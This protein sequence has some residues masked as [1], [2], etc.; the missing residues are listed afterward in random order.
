MWFDE[1]YKFSDGTLKKVR[2]ELHHRIHDFRLEYNKMM[3]RRKWTAIDRKRDIPLDRIEVLRYDKK[4]KS[5]KKEKLQTKTELTLEQTQQ[6]VSD[7]VLEMEVFS[8]RDLNGLVGDYNPIQTLYPQQA[9]RQK[10]KEAVRY[11]L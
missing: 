1:L 6:G 8:L 2:D 4:E 7:E 11:L 3:P 10:I 5:E 9:N